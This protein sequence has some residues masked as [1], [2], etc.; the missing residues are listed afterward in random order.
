[1]KVEVLNENK[2]L[3]TLISNIS[4]ETKVSKEI[5]DNFNPLKST[6]KAKIK[7]YL[8]GKTKYDITLLNSIV[9]GYADK[10][11]STSNKKLNDKEILEVKNNIRKAFGKTTNKVKVID[12]M[13]PTS[14]IFK[15]LIEAKE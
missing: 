2:I 9:D 10:V 15:E 5:F 8:D 14:Q 4:K 13:S 12:G 11:I 1:M 7:N 3:D 6:V